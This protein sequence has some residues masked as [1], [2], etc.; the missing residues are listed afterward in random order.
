LTGLEEGTLPSRRNGP[1]VGSNLDT[2]CSLEPALR[3]K[4][5]VQKHIERL[6][7]LESVNHSSSKIVTSTGFEVDAKIFAIDMGTYNG[8]AHNER[9]H[10]SHGMA[11]GCLPAISLGIISECLSWYITQQNLPYRLFMFLI[12]SVVGT[13]HEIR[14]N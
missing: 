8:E 10:A 6:H 4:V 2:V 7:Y 14:V 3:H 13:D 5:T 9:P 11:F 12:F 1:I